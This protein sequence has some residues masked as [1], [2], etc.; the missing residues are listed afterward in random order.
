MKW[1]SCCPGRAIASIFCSATASRYNDNL[2]TDICEHKYISI[3]LWASF[4]YCAMNFTYLVVW[5]LCPV[6]ST[7]K[8]KWRES[9]TACACALAALG[10]RGCFVVS[11]G[12]WPCRSDLLTAKFPSCRKLSGAEQRRSRRQSGPPHP[13]WPV[14]TRRP[15]AILATSRC[16]RFA[17]HSGHALAVSL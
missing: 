14:R 11:Y 16:W 9:R 12:A 7:V 1:P 15:S 6:R 2:R 8:G 3:F 5:S 10:G 4:I 13:E 17:E